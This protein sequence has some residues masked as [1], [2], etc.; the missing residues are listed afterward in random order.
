MALLLVG[1]GWALS[2]TSPPILRRHLSTRPIR[3]SAYSTETEASTHHARGSYPAEEIR[4]RHNQ[5]HLAP[6]R[7]SRFAGAS[8]ANRPEPFRQTGPCAIK[9][10]TYLSPGNPFQG[11][12]VILPPR[13]CLSLSLAPFKPAPL[14][15][16]SSQAVAARAGKN[17]SRKWWR[18]DNTLFLP[19]P[20][21]INVGFLLLFHPVFFLASPRGGGRSED[22]GT[23]LAPSILLVDRL[24]R[25]GRILRGGGRSPVPL[26]RIRPHADGLSR[27]GE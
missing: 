2:A 6:H 3:Q 12:V 17:D 18:H 9:L 14:T 16:T 13:S 15:Q 4:N 21:C 19:T 10:P 23:G 20:S 11:Y 26:K 24:G 1:E 25:I 8:Q 7:R 22:A 27:W 5:S